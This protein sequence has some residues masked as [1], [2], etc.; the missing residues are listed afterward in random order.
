MKTFAALLIR[1]SL[2]PSRLSQ[3]H[4]AGITFSTPCSDRSGSRLAPGN[5][6]PLG[7]GDRV[8]QGEGV[9]A[10]HVDVAVPERRQA[11]QQ[12]PQPDGH[13]RPLGQKLLAKRNSPRQALL[14]L[15]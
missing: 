11:R 15:G 12:P 1:V 3:G 5:V 10:E 4:S 6:D 2:A 8:G 13:L 9:T 14:T 7:Q